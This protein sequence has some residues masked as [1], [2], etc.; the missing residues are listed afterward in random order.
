LAGHRPNGPRHGVPGRVRWPLAG[1]YLLGRGMGVGGDRRRARRRRPG[2][3][4]RRTG[5]PDGRTVLRG[6]EAVRW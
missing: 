2:R 3:Y 4:V 5:E 6:P 1:P